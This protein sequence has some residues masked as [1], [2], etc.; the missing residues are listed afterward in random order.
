M[1]ALVVWAL[2]LPHPRNAAALAAP[3]PQYFITALVAGSGWL[4]P[5]MP[6]AAFVAVLLIAA[7]LHAMLTQS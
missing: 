6:R 5:L 7:G 1:A 2:L 4:G 3:W